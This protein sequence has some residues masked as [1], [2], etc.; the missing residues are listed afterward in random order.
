MACTGAGR[1][2]TNGVPTGALRGL[3]PRLTEGQCDHGGWVLQDVGQVVSDQAARGI[4]VAGA[5]FG[6]GCNDAGGGVG[7]GA[8]SEPAG[9]GGGSDGILRAPD[10]AGRARI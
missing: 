1:H 10:R 4:A 3:T 2:L 9:G 5:G 7:G 6:V 8:D